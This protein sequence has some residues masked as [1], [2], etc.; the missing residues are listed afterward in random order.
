MLTMLRALLDGHGI[1]AVMRDQLVQSVH[2][3]S[4]GDAGSVT[5]F[6]AA[7]NADRALSPSPAR[8]LVATATG[9]APILIRA[10]TGPP[11]IFAHHELWSRPRGNPWFRQPQVTLR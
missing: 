9:T 6:V 10:T 3:F 8:S 11:M 2:P 1:P 7:A 5:L 4:V